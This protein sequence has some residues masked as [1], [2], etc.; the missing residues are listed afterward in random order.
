MLFFYL[1]CAF[2]ISF[3]LIHNFIG[4][5]LLLK[6]L[7]I[8]M[9]AIKYMKS[10]IWFSWNRFIYWMLCALLFSPTQFFI[11]IISSHLFILILTVPS[12]RFWS[13]NMW[14]EFIERRFQ[15]L[16]SCNERNIIVW[17]LFKVI[18]SYF[19]EMHLFWLIFVNILEI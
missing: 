3:L 19:A 18:C 2:W 13:F 8:M 9:I 5:L 7:K 12:F 6:K 16:I 11:S 1:F 17:L 15:C 10:T 4:N 14:L